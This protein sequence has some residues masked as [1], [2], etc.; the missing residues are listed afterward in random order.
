MNALTDAD[1]ATVQLATDRVTT[2]AFELA[3]NVTALRTVARN[4]A[5]T[6][7]LVVTEAVARLALVGDLLGEV[8]RRLDQHFT[9]IEGLL[10]DSRV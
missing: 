7:A 9:R 6:P 4:E 2:A 1:L 5:V 3:K 10:R 8:R